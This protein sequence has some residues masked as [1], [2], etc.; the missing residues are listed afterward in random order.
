VDTT[1]LNDGDVE[2]W[3]VIQIAGPGSAITLRNL[4]TGKFM[5]F[6]SLALTAGEAVTIDTR[7]KTVL[8]SDNTSVYS[9]LSATSSMWSLPVG[10]NAIRLE[11]GNAIAG[12]SSMQISYR[13][14][15]LS[16]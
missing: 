15:F 14:K 16:P 7:D 6:T 1:I 3:P 2:V 13:R 8:K 12:S 5:Q 11:M 4:T 9:D 10:T